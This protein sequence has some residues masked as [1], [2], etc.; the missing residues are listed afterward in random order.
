MIMHII[1]EQEGAQK[2]YLC[3]EVIEDTYCTISLPLLPLAITSLLLT[4]LL[5][6]YCTIT[7]TS[8]ACLA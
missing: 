3:K 1:I 6:T 2:I 4:P 5:A 7:L 8:R